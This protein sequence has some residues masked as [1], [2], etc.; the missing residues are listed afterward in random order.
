MLREKLANDNRGVALLLTVLTTIIIL[1][2][3]I[4]YL[5]FTLT[6]NKISKSQIYGVKTYY[7]AEAGIADMI[8]KLKNDESYKTSFETNPAWS[9]NFT[10]TNP[11]GSGTGSYTVSIANSNLAR[12]EITSTGIFDAGGGKISQRI[13]KTQVYKAMGTSGIGSNPGYAD[14]NIDINGSLVD[15]HNGSAHSNGNF[16]VNGASTVD[17]DAD[18]EAVGNF[19]KVWF[20]TV[21]VAGATHAA[22]YPPAAAPI[23]MPAIDFDSADS[24][25]YKNKATV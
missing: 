5:S 15:F 4:Y 10:R 12:G 14:G 2:L 24:N 25:S 16:I 7:L 13:I 19:N 20:S 21:N 17:I 18:L 11:F 6:E 9:E 1:F 23:P 8:W 22:N 3:A